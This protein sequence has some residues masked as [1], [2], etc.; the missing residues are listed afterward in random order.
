MYYEISE[1]LNA[2]NNK[3][4]LGYKLGSYIIPTIKHKALWESKC[5]AYHY[6]SR[7]VYRYIERHTIRIVRRKT[8]AV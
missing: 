4:K 8:G 1:N 6:H 3:I 5:S 7:D 2:W